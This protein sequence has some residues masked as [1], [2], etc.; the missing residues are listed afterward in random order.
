MAWIPWHLAL[1]VLPQGAAD[2]LRDEQRQRELRAE[3]LQAARLYARLLLRWGLLAAQA[4]AAVAALLGSAAVLYALFYYLVIPS[5]FHEQAVFLDY[6]RHASL[7]RSGLAELTLPRAVLNL[8]TP[9]HQWQ[10]SEL[11][12]APPQTPTVLVP[13]VKYDVIVELDMPESRVNMDVGMF[14]VA[15]E[16]R[17]QDHALLASSARAAI[18]RD[19]HTL[20]R[21]MR[22]AFWAVPYALGFSD[23]TQ[24]VT[25]LAIN[26][27]TESKRFPT[28]EVVVRL[29]N[30]EVQV[31]AAKLTIIAQL[32]GFRYLMYHWSVPTAIL[33][34]LNI[35]FLEALALGILYL[36]YSMEQLT[37]DA[38]EAPLAD[39]MAELKE[40]VA[41]D[42]GKQFEH[43]RSGGI[44]PVHVERS[45]KLEPVDPSTIIDQ[46]ATG[47]LLDVKQEQ[48]VELRYRS[49][50]FV[51]DDE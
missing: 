22:V 24:K 50:H 45:V 30:P 42:K 6:G 27:F 3:L 39:A 10:A 49:T 31:Y 25:V 44:P 43:H 26:G 18:V 29:N 14:M 2:L 9:T 40:E 35:A 1:L 46:A 7:S 20:V 33:V 34:I 51:A 21:W 19:S 11:V 8:H 13:G 38:S 41:A 17:A 37:P 23:P 28:T 4:A 32:T 47:E 48:E 12:D 15:T 16:L 5:R 36:F